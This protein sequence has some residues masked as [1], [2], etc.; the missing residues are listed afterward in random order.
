MMKANGYPNAA[1]TL[2]IIEQRINEQKGALNEMPALPNGNEDP[3]DQ[4]GT[5]GWETVP[6]DVPGMPEQGMYQL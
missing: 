1:K 3:G 2:S 5:E 6:E 4:N